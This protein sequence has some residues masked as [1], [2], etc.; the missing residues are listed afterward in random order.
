MNPDLG[1]NAMQIILVSRLRTLWYG[2]LD[3]KESIP[4]VEGHKKIYIMGFQAIKLCFGPKGYKI[5]V[6]EFKLGW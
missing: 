5:F 4:R 6:E 2:N 3:V 1:L